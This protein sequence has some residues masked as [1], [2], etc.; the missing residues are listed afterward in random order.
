MK[1][2]INIV[3]VILLLALSLFFKVNGET[4]K[5][6]KNFGADILLKPKNIFCLDGEIY[7]QDRG[8]ETILVFSNDG[9]FKTKIGKKGAGPGEF[10]YLSYLQVDKQHL[11]VYDPGQ[12][13]IHFLDRKKR[14]YLHSKIIS[15]GF[16]YF[17]PWGFIVLPGQQFYFCTP[18]ELKTDFLIH[19]TTPDLRKE[20]SFLAARPIYSNRAESQA[21]KKLSPKV[22]FNFGYLAGNEKVIYFAYYLFNKVISISPEGKRLQE[23][24]IPLPSMEKTA[25]VKIIGPGGAL[26]SKLNY[27]LKLKDN[28]LFLLSRNPAGQSVLYLL[29]KN[30]LKE[31]CRMKEELLGFDIVGNRVYALHDGEEGIYIYTVKK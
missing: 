15:S 28:R 8:E 19:K 27:D 21:Q 18:G 26:E 11:Y 20:K 17:N 5:P 31:Y 23:Y 6:V 29:E 2:R 7:V 22:F 12:F 10:I 16:A 4:V 24:D 30:G 14:K 13:R 3:N 25:K 1:K 9:A